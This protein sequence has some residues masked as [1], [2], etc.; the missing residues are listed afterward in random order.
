MVK[1]ARA[2]FQTTDPERLRVAVKLPHMLRAR[3]DGS[4]LRIAVRLARG[5]A[6]ASDVA[7]REVS[8][9]GVE[10]GAQAFALAA[11][12]VARLRAFRAR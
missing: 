2:D 5:L 6:E 11:A 12:D 3:A 1:L 4:V 9:T 7:L 10:P 8:E